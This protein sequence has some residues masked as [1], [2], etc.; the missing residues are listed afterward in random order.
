[1]ET[2]PRS[3]IDFDRVEVA[4]EVIV[5]GKDKGT[6]PAPV[7]SPVLPGFPGIPLSFTGVDVF[8][9]A[10]GV[11]TTGVVFSFPASVE[12]CRRLLV[13]RPSFDCVGLVV[14]VFESIFRAGSGGTS[15][16]LFFEDICSLSFFVPLFL[17]PPI[18][19]FNERKDEDRL[20]LLN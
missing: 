15:L 8:D 16:P 13:E 5:D 19:F 6:A 20:R 1:M 2:D 12:D 9:T 7:S 4:G 3:I 18:M 11:E 17:F 10:K 14:V